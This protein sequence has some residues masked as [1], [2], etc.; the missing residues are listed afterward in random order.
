MN[1]SLESKSSNNSDVYIASYSLLNSVGGTTKQVVTSVFSGISAYTEELNENTDETF[2]AGVFPSEL[3]P[4]AIEDKAEYL[5]YEKHFWQL[6]KLGKLCI[7]EFAQSLPKGMPPIPL[8]VLTPDWNKNATSNDFRGFAE[9]LANFAGVRQQFSQVKEICGGRS[10]G[11]HALNYAVN[12]IKRNQTELIAIGS[13]DSFQNLEYLVDV[14][15]RLLTEDAMDGFIPGE[16]AAFVL[17]ANKKSVIKHSLKN[18]VQIK[19]IQSSIEKGHLNSQL[20]YTGDGL[21]EAIRLVFENG[22]EKTATVFCSMNG[23][24]IWA[25]EWGVGYLRNRDHFCENLEV[26]HPAEFYGDLGVATGL[27]LTSFA[28]ETILERQSDDSVLVWCSDDYESRYA[29]LLKSTN[30]MDKNQ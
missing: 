1:M 10:A 4:E 26:N 8:L 17:L 21:S 12:M 19:S 7:R 9:S 3:L 15:D 13:I 11:L 22:E 18:I 20:P 5:G 28:V 2:T 14:E 16:G 24:G 25:K 30:V 27:T 29:M 6:L 23:E